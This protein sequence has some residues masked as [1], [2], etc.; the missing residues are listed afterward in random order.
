MAYWKDLVEIIEQ[1]TC[2]GY[3]IRTENYISKMYVLVFKFLAAIMTKWSSKSSIARLFR[4]F[5]SEFFKTEIED[6]TTKIRDL[7]YRLRRQSDLAMQRNLKNIIP[8]ADMAQLITDSQANFQ[9][10]WLIVLNQQLLNLGQTVKITLEEQ[11]RSQRQEQLESTR[12]TALAITGVSSSRN[13]S[14]ILEDSGTRGEYYAVSQVQL[15]A[16]QQLRA[17]TSQQHIPTLAVQARF[18]NVHGEIL[19]R[20][21]RWNAASTSQ[22]LWIQGPFQVPQPSRYTQLSAYVVMTAQKANVP[23]LYYFCDSTTSTVDLILTLIAQL[24][25]ALPNDFRSEFDFSAARFEALNQEESNAFDRAIILF[26][27]LLAVGPYM[28]FVIIDG[29]QTLDRSSNRAQLQGLVDVLRSAG[30]D[31]RAEQK[32]VTKTLFTTDGFTDVLI[33]LNGAE[34]MSGVDFFGEGGAGP[35]IDGIEVGFL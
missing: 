4:S 13:P 19:N 14:P 24:V 6:K 26:K 3:F 9:A 35:E 22:T 34:R 27:D 32:R 10:E 28:L 23:A 15:N 31:E 16:L 8:K 21:Q 17:Y 7:E 25:R 12:R 30:K 11:Y 20:I 29:L 5:D 2:T 18:L 1:N 33:R